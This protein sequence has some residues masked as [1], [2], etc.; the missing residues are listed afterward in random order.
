MAARAVPLIAAGLLAL[1]SDLAPHTAA[2]RQ[3]PRCAVLI[4]EPGEKGDPLT[5]PRLTIHARAAFLSRT[6]PDHPEARARFLAAQPKAALYIDFGDFHLVRLVPQGGLLN[7]G[8]GRAY[9]LQATEL[10]P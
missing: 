2:L 7:A 4:G 8:F 10:R 9:Q 5:H 3:D 1:M 6:A